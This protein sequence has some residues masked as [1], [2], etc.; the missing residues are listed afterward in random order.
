MQRHRA[1]K[2]LSTAVAYSALPILAYAAGTFTGPIVPSGAATCAAGFGAFSQI[3]EGVLGLLISLGILIA[4]LI[5]AYGGFLLVL[6]PMNPENRTTAKKIMI[7]AAIGFI[8]TLG[9]WLIVNTLLT[10]LGAGGVLGATQGLLG[11]GTCLQVHT[12]TA[13]NGGASGSTGLDGGNTGTGECPG[14]LICNTQNQ[15]QTDPNLDPGDGTAGAACTAPGQQGNCQAPL[16]CDQTDVCSTPPGAQNPQICNSGTQQG[17]GGT[18]T[19]GMN[20]NNAVSYLNAHAHQ[21]AGGACWTAVR[22]AICAGGLSSFCQGGGYNAYQAGPYLTAA[23]FTQV[24]SGTYGPGSDTAFAYQAGDVAIFQ[25][26]SGHTNGHA[27]M[28]TGS[29]WVSD[30]FQNHMASNYTDYQGGSFAVYRP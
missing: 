20:V 1:I 13:I 2:L 28:Y 24:Y 15:C 18:G 4:V 14:F 22:S 12:Q 27:T 6:N 21:T 26:V 7:N 11:G 9:A 19:S 17:G 16:T 3:L 29:R 10:T 30:F 25:P 5:L 23:K 8:L